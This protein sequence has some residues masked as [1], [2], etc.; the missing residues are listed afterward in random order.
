MCDCLT[1]SV[2][3]GVGVRI[4]NYNSFLRRDV[5]M[6]SKVLMTS[7]LRTFFV[8]HVDYYVPVCKNLCLV[9]SAAIKYWNLLYKSLKILENNISF[10]I[11]ACEVKE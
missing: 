7:Q 1:V 6:R 11:M 5:R 10:H 3:G 2:L 9:T 8:L 4:I